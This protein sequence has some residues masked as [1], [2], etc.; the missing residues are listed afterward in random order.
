MR[1]APALLKVSTVQRAPSSERPAAAQSVLPSIGAT[2]PSSET[3]IFRT[4]ETMRRF[5]PSRRGSGKEDPR[6][7][8]NSSATQQLGPD[9]RQAP[10]AATIQPDRR[11]QD[12]ATGGPRP[13]RLQRTSSMR[14]KLP[15]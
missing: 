11:D 13:H 10:A 9:G 3:D 15:A 6:D 5:L 8:P 7:P 4:S 1:C 12:S 14:I 2:Y